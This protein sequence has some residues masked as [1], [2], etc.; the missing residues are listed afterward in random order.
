MEYQKTQTVAWQIQR[1]KEASNFL[2]QQKKQ[3][4]N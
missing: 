3:M 1:G 4:G 2:Q